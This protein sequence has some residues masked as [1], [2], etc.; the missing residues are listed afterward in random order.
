M[1]TLDAG[2]L[3]VIVYFAVNLVVTLSALI[4]GWFCAWTYIL[5]KQALVQDLFFEPTKIIQA[6]PRGQP[7]EAR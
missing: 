7:E 2:L 3:Y 6:S 1:V 4:V 5:R